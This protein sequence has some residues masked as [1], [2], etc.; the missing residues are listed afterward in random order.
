MGFAK[1]SPRAVLQ[2]PITS[3]SLGEVQGL[4]IEQSLV[5]FSRSC[6]SLGSAR[7]ARA[8]RS[9]VCAAPLCGGPVSCISKLVTFPAL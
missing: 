4:Q 9:R 5:V 6:L 3:L 8:T 2:L 7:V 1:L